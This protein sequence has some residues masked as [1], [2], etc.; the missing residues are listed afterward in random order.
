MTNDE[1][2]QGL[3]KQQDLT[4]A[5][6]N[7]LRGIRD[8]VEKLLAVLEGRPRFYYGGSYGKNTIIRQKYDL[9]IVVYWPKDTSYTIKGIYEGVGK[10]L[11]KEW[12]SVNSKTVAW[13]IPFQSGFHVDVVPGRALDDGYVEANLYRTDTGTTLKTS[14]K[15]HIGV[16]RNSNR[17]DAIRL[18]KLWRE[19]KRVPFKKSF[20]L[21]IMTIEGS[22]GQNSL[23][24]QLIYAFR[25]IRDK[26]ETTK[27]QDP[28]NSNNSLSDDISYT[29]K[30]LIKLAAQAALDAKSW[31][32]VFS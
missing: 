16:V 23:E 22:K 14:I 4:T 2:F 8:K 29:D 7:V 24:N 13:E 10:Q 31:G 3:L 28:A 5:E 9:D 32:E 12:G 27:I 18:M 15:T 25:Y 26:I 30:V 6:Y 19:R 11:K 21:E 20:L 17:R 1:Y